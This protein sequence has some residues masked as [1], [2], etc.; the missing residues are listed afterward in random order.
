MVTLN[1]SSR[2]QIL[3]SPSDTLRFQPVL[4]SLA[5]PTLV[6]G[7][8]NAKSEWPGPEDNYKETRMLNR[9]MTEAAG[10]RCLRFSTHWDLSGAG[11]GVPPF[12]H[13]HPCLFSQQRS[14]EGQGTAW[15]PAWSVRGCGFCGGSAWEPLGSPWVSGGGS[16]P[17]TMKMQRGDVRGAVSE[18]PG[19]E[20]PGARERP[21]LHLA[22]NYVWPAG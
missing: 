18:V 19:A 15:S 16:H 12:P 11:G 5:R 22:M 10:I 9:R 20:R 2:L 7:P 21:R 1:L 6:C 8:S 4:M 17:A 3:L 14:S 13:P